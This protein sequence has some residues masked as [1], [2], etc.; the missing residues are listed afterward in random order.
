M[1]GGYLEKLIKEFD[2]RTDLTESISHDPVELFKVERPELGE[3]YITNDELIREITC[4]PHLVGQ[5]FEDRCLRIAEKLSGPIL[6]IVEADDSEVVFEH[7][8]RASLGY[9]L[10]EALKR[11]LE[12]R[13]VSVR[14]RYKTTSYRD[15]QTREIEVVYQDL[16]DFPENSEI[17]LFKPDTEATGNSAEAS[18]RKLVG[19]AKKSGSRVKTLVL[20]GFISEDGLTRINE[21]SEDLGI[22]KVYSFAFA[23]LSKL[24]SNGYDMLMYGM[25][26]S[27]F[28]EHGK[29][30]KIGGIVSQ[31]TLED[32]L[33]FYIPGLDQPGDFSARQEKVLT[34]DGWEPGGIEE[35][36]TNSVKLIK[37][38]RELS[39]DEWW[40]KDFHDRRV[41]EELNSLKKEMQE[42]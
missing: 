30:R 35:H 11:H 33:E 22:E 24:A 37:N 20:Y 17:V 36:L 28:K 18:L 1:E 10:H 3:A 5:K 27:Y 14:P 40:W 12:F 31:E 6:D 9:K 26:F 38:V 21:I 13:E 39:S 16:E 32:Y 34:G 23:N 19:E 42:F 7:V 41:E 25:D 8:L 2:I 29:R 15:H 4:S